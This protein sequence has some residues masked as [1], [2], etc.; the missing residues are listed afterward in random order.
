[1]MHARDN[2]DLD[3]GLK[4]CKACDRDFYPTVKFVDG[5][6]PECAK[7]KAILDDQFGKHDD[8]S[9]EHL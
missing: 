3:P 5:L 7:K 4:W 6:C 2:L 1:M 9:E 8:E